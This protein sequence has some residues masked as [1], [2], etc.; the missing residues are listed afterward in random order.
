MYDL[1]RLV[2]R[3]SRG[4]ANARDLRSLAATLSVVPDI[5]DHLAD[6]DAR[7]LADLHATLDPLAETREEIE[8]AIRPDPPQQVTEG[9]VIRDGYDEELDDCARPSR[10]ARNGSSN[11]KRAS[12]SAPASTR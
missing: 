8:A 2:S 9:G 6:A 1:E 5:R 12:A 3:V 10:P 4:R 11:W 7:L